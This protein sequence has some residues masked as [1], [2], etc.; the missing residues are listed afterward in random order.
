MPWVVDTDEPPKLVILGSIPRRGAK[1][2]WSSRSARY[3][4][5]VEVVGS[6]PIRIAKPGDY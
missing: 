6:S 4:V 1:V 5:T 3:P 2:L